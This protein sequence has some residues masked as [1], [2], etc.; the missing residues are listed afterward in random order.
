M[1]YVDQD[2]FI[3]ELKQLICEADYHKR[4]FSK[5]SRKYHR[6]DYWLRSV[7]GLIA[8]LGIFVSGFTDWRLIGTLISGLSAFV[9]ANVLPAFKWD[10]ILLAFRDEQDDW[11][12][13][14]HGYEDLL[15]VS[16]LAG[17]DEILLQEFQRIREMQNNAALNEKLLPK[18]E[19]LLEEIELEVRQYYGLD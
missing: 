6:V 1:S 5:Q 18:N 8:L 17:R 7:L 3:N 11:T 16:K 15:R 4:Y 14:H 12:R 13:I 9:L 19:E 2:K 10:S